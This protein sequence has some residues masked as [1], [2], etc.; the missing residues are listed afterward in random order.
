[1][2]NRQ[3]DKWRDKTES[4]VNISGPVFVEDDE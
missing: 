2:K 3:P 1:L 4:T